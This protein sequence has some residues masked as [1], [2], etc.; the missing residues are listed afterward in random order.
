M[1]T[2]SLKS[3]LNVLRVCM[4]VLSGIFVGF[5]LFSFSASRKVASDFWTALGISQSAASSSI[6]NSFMNG[7]LE[8]Y[9]VR[10]PGNIALDKRAAIAKD[11]LVYTK[12]FFASENFRKQYEKERLTA[13][14]QKDE[15]KVRTK[16]QVRSEEVARLEKNRVDMAKAFQAMGMSA[17]DQ[18]KSL[19]EFDEMLAEYKKPN[20]MMIDAIYEGEV[21][22]AKRNEEDY[23]Q[24]VKKWEFEYPADHNARLKRHIEKY[25]KLA[26]T[27]DFSAQLKDRYG[28]KVFVNSA[29]EG[30]GTDWKLIFRAGKEV[31]DVTKP[32]AE[33]WLKEL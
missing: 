11:M 13:K 5:F 19:D 18:K 10:N 16:E 17:A 8:H 14:P 27:V 7:Y 26:A 9:S 33:S 21:G 22:T 15:M 6:R 25:L 20:S 30:K 12:A 32:F 29:Y 1:K 4:I 2:Y 3:T 31:Y 28:K 23:Q 24:R